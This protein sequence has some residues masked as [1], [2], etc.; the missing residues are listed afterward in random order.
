MFRDMI[1]NVPGA[2]GVVFSTH[3]HNDLGL[4]VAN[5]LAGVE[6]GARLGFSSSHGHVSIIPP[7]EA[8][9][10]GGASTLRSRS[11]V[12]CLATHGKG[13]F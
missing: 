8:D 9:A 1:E 3:C 7:D 6:A 5:S 10:G 13:S 4:A 2:D 12:D 11:N